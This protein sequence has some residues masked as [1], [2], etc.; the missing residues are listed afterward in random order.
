MSTPERAVVVGIAAGQRD[1]VVLVAAEFAAQF[2]AQLVCVVADEGHYTSTDR[3]GRTVIAPID[4]DSVDDVEGEWAGIEDHL[5]DVLD[6]VTPRWT[7]RFVTGE[8]SAALVEIATEVDA[9]MVVIG[10]RRRSVA[11]SLREFFAGSIAAHLAHRQARP[12]VVVPLDPAPLDDGLPWHDEDA[13]D[14]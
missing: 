12:V 1:A 10:T 14:R 7:V 4:P 9:L 2:D 11:R 13:S 3:T 5:H 6:R 8:P